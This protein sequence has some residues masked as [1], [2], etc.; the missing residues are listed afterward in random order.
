[1]YQRFRP[2]TKA[3]RQILGLGVLVPLALYGLAIYTDVS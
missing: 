3:T 1:M 2:T